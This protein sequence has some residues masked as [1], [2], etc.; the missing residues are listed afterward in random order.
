MLPNKFYYHVAK[1]WLKMAYSKKVADSFFSLTVVRKKGVTRVDISNGGAF[2]KLRFV[3][4]VI[5]RSG[6]YAKHRWVDS[7][8]LIEKYIQDIDNIPTYYSVRFHPNIDCYQRCVSDI[9]Q[10]KNKVIEYWQ[11]TY[12]TKIS[13]PINWVI[14]EV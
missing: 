10:A 8:K 12:K 9:E 13:E 2:L 5:K 4:G 6:D 1:E 11:Y 14:K 3:D 7:K